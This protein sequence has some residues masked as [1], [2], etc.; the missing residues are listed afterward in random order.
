MAGQRP[1]TYSRSTTSASPHPSPEPDDFAV[2]G[3]GLEESQSVLIAASEF[4]QASAAP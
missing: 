2:L 3:A 1:T 4:G